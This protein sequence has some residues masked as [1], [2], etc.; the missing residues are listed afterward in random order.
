MSLIFQC[1]DWQESDVKTDTIEKYKDKYGNDK[2]KES[3]VNDYAIRTYGRVAH[4]EDTEPNQSICLQI[5]GFHPFFYIKVPKKWT[6]IEA[7]IFKDVFT[8]D[9]IKKKLRKALYDQEKNMS[10]LAIYQML[11]VVIFFDRIADHAE[12]VEGGIRSL[13]AK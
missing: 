1:I 8:A 12:N 5:T 7:G 9:K 13:V 3:Y 2:V 10:M 4:N 6:Q 11:R